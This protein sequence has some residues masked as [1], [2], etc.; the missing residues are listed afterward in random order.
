MK[1][2]K[3]PAQQAPHV[4]EASTPLLRDEEMAGQVMDFASPPWAPASIL[5]S[6]LASGLRDPMSMCSPHELLRNPRLPELSLAVWTEAGEVAVPAELGEFLVDDAFSPPPANSAA[7][8]TKEVPDKLVDG[9]CVPIDLLSQF[10]AVVQPGVVEKEDAQLRKLSEQHRRTCDT[11]Q[12]TEDALLSARQ[13]LVHQK[14]LHSATTERLQSRIDDL[15]VQV[16]KLVQT[17]DRKSTA[18]EG[19]GAVDT[20]IQ[21]AA[22]TLLSLARKLPP[23][24]TQVPDAL[25]SALEKLRPANYSRVDKHHAAW[26]PSLPVVLTAWVAR[27]SLSFQDLQLFFAQFESTLDMPPPTATPTGRPPPESPIVDLTGADDP[28]ISALP[29]KASESALTEATVSMNCEMDHAPDGVPPV[30]NGFLPWLNAVE[31]KKVG[32]L[33]RAL[34]LAMELAGCDV[35]N[36]PHDSLRRQWERLRDSLPLKPTVTQAV[37]DF[38]KAHPQDDPSVPAVSQSPAVEAQKTN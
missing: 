15:Q 26:Y 30:L 22:T 25:Q 18:A 28:V 6:H 11:L 5:A 20:H 4:L 2:R 16:T 32:G 37:A 21:P 27:G 3:I 14:K 12:A 10:E 31:D 35:P 19:T 7:R 33:A 38:V 17:L 1:T 9:D 23:Q 13:D 34:H 8:T 29:P 36:F 24:G